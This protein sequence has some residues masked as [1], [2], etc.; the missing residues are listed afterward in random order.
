MSFTRYLEN[1]PTEDEL[2]DAAVLGDSAAPPATPAAGSLA[3]FRGR[4]VLVLDRVDLDEVAKLDEVAALV[5]EYQK[6]LGK[7]PDPAPAETPESKYHDR[8]T[9]LVESARS[10]LGLPTD[11]AKRF[12]AKYRQ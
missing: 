2:R 5:R 10:M 4:M 8:R 9:R 1:N 11:R 6:M 12:L 3:A 7:L